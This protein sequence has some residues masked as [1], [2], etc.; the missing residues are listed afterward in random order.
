M[1]RYQERNNMNPGRLKNCSNEKEKRFVNK[2]SKMSDKALIA[3]IL[4][5]DG[6]GVTDAFDRE[7]VFIK[8]ELMDR[9]YREKTEVTWVKQNKKRIT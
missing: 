4:K 8:L 3:L 1:D 5:R 9:G 2:I 6:Q 7:N